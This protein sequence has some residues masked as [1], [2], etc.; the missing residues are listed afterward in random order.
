M[1]KIILACVLFLFYTNIFAQFNIEQALSAFDEN[2][3]SGANTAKNT[4]YLTEKEKQMIFYVNLA[5]MKPDI[6]LTNIV[7]VYAEGR[8]DEG[9]PSLK[10][11]LAKAKSIHP[12]L[13]HKPL[14]D[15]AKYHAEDMG[16][17]GKIG[18][19]STNGTSFFDR[20]NKY[21][22]G[23]GAMAENCA[24]GY[25]DPFES[26]MQLLIDNNVASRGHRVN[27]LNKDYFS[28]GVSIKPHQQYSFN[29]VQDFASIKPEVKT[30][31]NVT[32][33]K[34]IVRVP[35]KK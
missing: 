31:T 18:H 4:P 14:S 28:I 19:N 9:M 27:I 15:A 5:R 8:D 1:K 23:G 16:K 25:E 2:I 34:K 10:K 12:F 22:K 35:K 24:Y 26:V 21:V 30:N 6:F 20:L 33:P 11:D 13:P 7:N 3:L 17:A 32:P 29:S